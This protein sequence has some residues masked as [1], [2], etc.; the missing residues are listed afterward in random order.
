MLYS[1]DLNLIFK[2]TWT[3]LINPTL[4]YLPY[5]SCYFTPILTTPNEKERSYFLQSV[6]VTA[7]IS[8][9]T[10]AQ[11]VLSAIFLV[12]VHI[13]ASTAL[14]VV[15]QMLVDHWS[16]KQTPDSES[17]GTTVYEKPP[18]SW[19]EAAWDLVFVS[20]SKKNKPSLFLHKKQ[21][22]TSGWGGG[23]RKFHP[24]TS[25]PR[26]KGLSWGCLRCTSPT[27]SLVYLKSWF[28]VPRKHQ[29]YC[30]YFRPP[31]KKVLVF[32][33]KNYLYSCKTKVWTFSQNMYYVQSS[34]FTP[35]CLLNKG[36][37]YRIHSFK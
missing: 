4:K 25:V 7:F 37:F 35:N 31:L 18:F 14:K 34:H 9:M 26:T 19:W 32:I 13:M 21:Q 29:V 15:V 22:N 36:N 17:G 33:N 24:L 23:R 12:V 16:H 8:Y 10:D 1:N 27:L 2:I 5:R 30:K 3:K 11:R 28:K 20:K 6:H